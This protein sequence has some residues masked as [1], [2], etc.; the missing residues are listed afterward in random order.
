M[1]R[2]NGGSHRAR[3]QRV[4]RQGSRRES[5]S[6]GTNAY[7]YDG[8]RAGRPAL[9]SSCACTGRDPSAVFR[10]GTVPSPPSFEIG[11]SRSKSAFQI[12][13]DR[14]KT[15]PSAPDHEGTRPMN[16]C[17]F[18]LALM[19]LVPVPSQ[20]GLAQQTRKQPVT[21]YERAVRQINPNE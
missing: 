2:E 9:A 14:G 15:S 21:W 19:L 10:T 11:Y 20:N 12:S 1:V 6:E 7:P 5:A 4:S 16:N 3:G 13:R 8:R 17:S 18:V